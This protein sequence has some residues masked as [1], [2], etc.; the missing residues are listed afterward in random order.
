M[1]STHLENQ[2]GTLPH[3]IL[4]ILFT[5]IPALIYTALIIALTFL[6]PLTIIT[7]YGFSGLVLSLFVP[8]LLSSPTSNVPGPSFILMVFLFFLTPLAITLFLLCAAATG[9][10]YSRK[11]LDRLIPS[12]QTCSRYEDGILAP[13]QKWRFVRAEVG[14]LPLH[15]EPTVREESEGFPGVGHR[16]G[17]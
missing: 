8:F 9:Y 12:S 16:L 10:M 4:L 15:Q 1:L 13:L 5:V 7:F 17:G 2:H 11:H 3:L 6:V 14:Y